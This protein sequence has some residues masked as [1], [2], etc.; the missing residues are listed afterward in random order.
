MDHT[1]CHQLHGPYWLSS[2]TGTILAVI[3]YITWT[4][5][6]V[7]DYMDHTGCYRLQGPYWLS[8][9]TW[10]YWLSSITLH[11]P[12]WLSSITG[13]ILA[14]I[15]YMDHTGCHRLHVHTGCHQLHYMDHTGCY[16]LHGPY[17]LSSSEPCFGLQNDRGVKS[18]NPYRHEGH[19]EQG[20][21]HR[22]A[23]ARHPPRVDLH[24]QRQQSG[25]V[26]YDVPRV[27]GSSLPGC[28]IGLHGDHTGATAE[29]AKTT[30]RKKACKMRPTAVELEGRRGGG[31]HI[32]LC[33]DCK[34][35]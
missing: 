34:I 21:G 30:I 32:N 4:I 22:G 18:A 6:A 29:N 10:T 33:F 2:I 7:I 15:D 27:V 1:G 9:I 13:T 12:Y 5:L 35:T 19:E 28:Q 16:E 3:N 11:G 25:A 26:A 31:C 14:V 20:H 17:R 23:D 8:S 24:H